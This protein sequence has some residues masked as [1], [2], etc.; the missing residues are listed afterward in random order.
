M[1]CLGCVWV[2]TKLFT[3][4]IIFLVC[5]FFS[6]PY[7]PGSAINLSLEK[8]CEVTLCGKRLLFKTK[9]QYTPLKRSNF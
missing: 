7:Y 3:E 2:C 1:P 6:Y 8:M 9:P 5:A 4:D